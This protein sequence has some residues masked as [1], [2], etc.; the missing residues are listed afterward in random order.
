MGIGEATP[1]SVT[2]LFSDLTLV[3]KAP[4][5]QPPIFPLMNAHHLLGSSG[6]QSDSRVY[7][8][9]QAQA[10]H[11]LHESF[12]LTVMSTFE[13]FVYACHSCCFELFYCVYSLLGSYFAMG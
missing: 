10:F 1:D 4:K 3:Q 13:S 5:K 6:V 8:E 12:Y 2:A 7:G 9:E 11:E